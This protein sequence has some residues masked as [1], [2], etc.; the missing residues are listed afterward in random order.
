MV[1]RFHCFSASGFSA[2]AV[3]AIGLLHCCPT[4]NAEGVWERSITYQDKNDLFANYYVGPCPCGTVAQMYI[5]PVP[6]PA[7]VGH[8]YTTYQPLMPHEFMY[9]HTR[10]HYAHAPGA[11]WTRSKV[12]WRTRGLNFQHVMHNLSP[13]F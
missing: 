9:K 6:V 11:G 10:S 8:T 1:C 13:E 3:V 2:L 4:A 7:N 5:S 12:R